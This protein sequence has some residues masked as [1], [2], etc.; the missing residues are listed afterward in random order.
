M[1]R[2]LNTWAGERPSWSQ[3]MGLFASSVM[4]LPPALRCHVASRVAC[5][6]GVRKE[7]PEAM[8]TELYC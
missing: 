3:N 1:G 6:T 8:Q 2:E 7:K 5:Y 4:I